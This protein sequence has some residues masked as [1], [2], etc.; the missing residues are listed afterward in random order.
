MERENRIY[1]TFISYGP[2]PKIQFMY[3]MKTVL[4]VAFISKMLNEIP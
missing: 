2:L 1:I 4:F 3:I